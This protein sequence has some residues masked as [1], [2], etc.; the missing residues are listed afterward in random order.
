MTLQR[1]WPLFVYV[2]LFAGVGWYIYGSSDGLYLALGEAFGALL[3]VGLVGWSIA[4]IRKKPVRWIGPTIIA[5]LITLNSMRPQLVTA[6][7]VHRFRDELASVP[8]SELPTAIVSHTDTSMGALM[9]TVIAIGK[10]SQNQIS[11][12]Y[13]DTPDPILQ[14]AL[15]IPVLAA[16]PSRDAV[17]TVLQAKLPTLTVLPGRITAVMDASRFQVIAAVNAD[18]DI[19]A[20]TRSQILAGYEQSHRALRGEYLANVSAITSQYTDLSDLIRFL[21][22]PAGTPALNGNGKLDFLSRDAVDVFRVAAG[23]IDADTRQI[24][25]V[26]QASSQRQQAM[27]ENMHT[28]LNH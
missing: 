23:K 6:F 27:L 28:M 2:V 18:A 15:D 8:A 4:L 17:L 1:L 25:D 20:N 19:P 5:G 13:A 16:Q 12:M 21:D 24:G 10:Q 14:H 11:A 7:D 22:T 3:L 26:L 9:A